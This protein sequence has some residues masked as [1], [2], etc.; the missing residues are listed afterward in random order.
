MPRART[1]Y[2]VELRFRDNISPGALF[3][4]CDIVD[5]P[6]EMRTLAT[7]RKFLLA[8][9]EPDS[10]PDFNKLIYADDGVALDELSTLAGQ[11]ISEYSQRPLTPPSPSAT[12][13][14]P[15]EGTLKVVSLSQGT[16]KMEPMSSADGQSAA[17]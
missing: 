3:D 9:L 6:S 16:V 5:D 17:S 13:P 2:G 4:I 11:L 1:L 12:G 8:A 10:V 7:I 15:T 14:E